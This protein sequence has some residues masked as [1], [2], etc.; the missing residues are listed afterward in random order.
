MKSEETNF[1]QLS[2]DRQRKSF[3]DDTSVSAAYFDTWFDETTV[4]HWRH[5]R[6]M[7]PAY[8]L[9]KWKKWVTVGDGRWGLDAIRLKKANQSISILPTDLTE[10]LLRKSRDRGY[11]ENY[12]VEYAEALSFR[13]NEFEVAFCKEAYHHFPRPF[14][15]LYE[16]LR[17]ASKAVILAEPNDQMPR[18]IMRGIL[19]ALR[20]LSKGQASPLVDSCFEDIGNYVYTIS[21]REII[22]VATSIQLPLVAFYEFDD[23]YIEGVEL[24]KR[25]DNGPMFKKIKRKLSQGRLLVKLGLRRYQHMISILFRVMPDQQMLQELKKNGFTLVKIPKNPYV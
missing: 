14:L 3:D 19:D 7:E 18:P 20:G 2:Y 24:E 15:A 6:M 23:H 10:N 9:L 11:I 12:S 17:V 16:M 25:A 21:K 13:D 22:K 5:M 4:D 8:P 1:H